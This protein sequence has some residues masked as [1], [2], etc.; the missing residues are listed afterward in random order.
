VDSDSTYIII[1]LY[2][3]YNIHEFNMSHRLSENSIRKL[4][5]PF[6]IADNRAS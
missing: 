1:Y 4:D 6:L 2:I 5:I 3:S